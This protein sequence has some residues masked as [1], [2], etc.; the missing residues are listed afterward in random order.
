[1]DK[2]ENMR[3]A[4]ILKQENPMQ[5]VSDVKDILEEYLKGENQSQKQP[6][7]LEERIKNAK[8]HSVIPVTEE[9]LKEL[10]KPEKQEEWSVRL[11]TI[12]NDNCIDIFDEDGAELKEDLEKFISQLLS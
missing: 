3:R 7:G 11:G 10:N 2:I 4:E 8:P 12:L 6:E 1:M 5:F 9:E